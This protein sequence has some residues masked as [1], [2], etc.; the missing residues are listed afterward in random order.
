ML[1]QMRATPATSV[2]LLMIRDFSQ[3][4][5]QISSFWKNEWRNMA[6]LRIS[7]IRL[8]I[9]QIP[10]ALIKAATFKDYPR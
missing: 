3:E 4:L 9:I 8:L 1:I 10:G 6:G 7:W 5:L 2:T